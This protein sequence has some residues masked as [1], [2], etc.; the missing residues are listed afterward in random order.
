MPVKALFWPSFSTS[1]VGKFITGGST[2]VRPAAVKSRNTTWRSWLHGV[3]SRSHL[4]DV[5]HVTPN[6][7]F[8]DKRAEGG[9]HVH[10]PLEADEADKE[11]KGRSMPWEML[12]SST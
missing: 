7:L 9:L 11:G 4:A 8:A 10:V 2:P 1:S 12:G 6:H 5:Q 3:V